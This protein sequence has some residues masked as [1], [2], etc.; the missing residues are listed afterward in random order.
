MFPSSEYSDS[1]RSIPVIYNPDIFRL[2]TFLAIRC[3]MIT[4]EIGQLN[5]YVIN[6]PF[7]FLLLLIAYSYWLTT[8]QIDW[9][10]F[11]IDLLEL[12]SSGSDI[13]SI[14]FK[15]AP[16]VS[17]WSFMSSYEKKTFKLNLLVFPFMFCAFGIVFKKF[18]P[19]L[20]FQVY[21]HYLFFSIFFS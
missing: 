1:H 4:K 15:H 9:A 11:L 2:F 17:G 18:L 16:P 7:E 19:I 8:F 12:M 13:S 20:G 6:W 21:R 10:S 14:H 3:E 5:T